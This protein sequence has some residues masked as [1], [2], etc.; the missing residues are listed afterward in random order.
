MKKYTSILIIFIVIISVIILSEFLIPDISIMSLLSFREGNVVLNL[1]II[2]LF[3]IVFIFPLL[4]S[5]K[6]GWANGLL[7]GSI[8]AVIYNFL[9]MYVK[10]QFTPGCTD[11]C[12]IENIVLVFVSFLYVVV[13]TIILTISFI[14]RRF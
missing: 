7:S 11:L 12:G 6:Y 9:D 2:L 14:K 1:Q 3:F 5:F 4:F 8:I 13:G 10:R